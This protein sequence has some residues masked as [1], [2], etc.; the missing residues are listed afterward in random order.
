MLKDQAKKV[1]P[2]GPCWEVCWILKELWLFQCFCWVMD[3]WYEWVSAS[4]SWWCRVLLCLSIVVKSLSSV[5]G[6][7]VEMWWFLMTLVVW[8][9]WCETLFFLRPVGFTYVFSSVVVGWAFP[10]EDYV[11]LLGIFNWVFWIHEWRLD[12]TDTF[13][14]NYNFVFC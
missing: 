14:E 10:V 11:S 2:W 1:P 5:F 13:K 7:F 12:G 8:F 4:F 6:C 3:L 9:L